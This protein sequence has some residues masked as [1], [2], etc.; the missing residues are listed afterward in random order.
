M[1]AIDQNY[2]QIEGGPIQHGPN[3]QGQ[4][5]GV[6]VLGYGSSILTGILV[7]FCGMF[8]WDVI[9]HY[10]DQLEGGLHSPWSPRAGTCP[11]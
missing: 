5:H 3:G 4:V 2:D 6:P 1:G 8:I 10:F 11:I 9:D 7:N